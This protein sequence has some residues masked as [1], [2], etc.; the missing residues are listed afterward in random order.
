[1]KDAFDLDGYRRAADV[2]VTHLQTMPW[3]FYPGGGASLESKCDGIR[4]FGDEIVAKLAEAPVSPVAET[5][6]GR[7]RG[8]EEGGVL[9]FRGVPYAAPPVGPLRFAA[10]EPAAA[11]SGVRDAARFGPAAPQRP[12]ALVRRLGL[13]GDEPQAEDCLSLNVWTP[14]LAGRRPVLVWLHGGAFIGGT[15]GVPLYDGARLAREGDVVVVTLNYR[16]GALGFLY[17][18]PGRGNFGLLDQ[19][20]ALRF[21]ARHVAALRRRSLAA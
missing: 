13:F 9:A 5:P 21:V 6:S 7:L 12:D 17:L 20:E 10:P 14:G 3:I 19:L 8:R 11:W 4:R 18:G 2:G 1:M 16:V 15:S